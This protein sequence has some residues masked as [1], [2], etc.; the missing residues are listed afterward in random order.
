M[1]IEGL[2]QELRAE[3][4]FLESENLHL[5]HEVQLLNAKLGLAR[6]TLLKMAEEL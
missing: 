5:I 2:V 3:I 1:Q 4:A 6:A